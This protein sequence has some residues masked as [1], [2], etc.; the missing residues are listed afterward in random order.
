MKVLLRNPTRE[1]DVAAPTRVYAVLEELRINRE[2]VLVIVNDE[3][4][5]GDR[6]LAE[7]DSVEIRSVIS[8]GA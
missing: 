5:P 1:I 2:G 3:L 7:T 8:G 6:K 4:I